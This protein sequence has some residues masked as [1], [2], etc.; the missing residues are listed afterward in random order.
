MVEGPIV[1]IGKPCEPAIEC[2]N[3]Q[4]PRDPYRVRVHADTRRGIDVDALSRL[5]E[6]L[7][8]EVLF[9]FPEPVEYS[10]A[11]LRVIAKHIVFTQYAM[12]IPVLVDVWA[13]RTTVGA[14]VPAA[15]WDLV[16]A[17]LV[18]CVGPCAAEVRRSQGKAPRHFHPRRPRW[19]SS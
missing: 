14:M 5:P 17:A 1:T 4:A 7:R 12:D 3:S 10:S 18:Q 11:E 19:R 8:L 16:H 9:R 2:R 15:Y 6:A 13:T